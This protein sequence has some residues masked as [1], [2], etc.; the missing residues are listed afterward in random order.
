M[1][2]SD[3]PL[4][5][6]PGRGGRAGGGEPQLGPAHDHDG[7]G[8]GAPVMEP[9][10]GTV[11]E[12]RGRRVA[13]LRFWALLAAVSG[14][15]VPL[16]WALEITPAS[17]LALTAIFGGGAFLLALRGYLQYCRVNLMALYEKGIAPPVKPHATVSRA[18]DF[19][20][21]YTDFARVE[22]EQNDLER[23][24]LAEEMFFRFTFHYEDGAR[25]VL[26]P[27]ILGRE[28]S[29]EQ[30][31]AF[32]DA[33]RESL[34]NS[35]PDRVELRTVLPDGRRPIASVSSARLGLRVGAQVREFAWDR[36]GKLR[37]RPARSGSA[38]NFETFDIMVDSEW[39]RLEASQIPR[40]NRRDAMAFLEEVMRVSR[41]RRVEV[42]QE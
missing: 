17:R 5:R 24:E 28:P 39:I 10:P 7:T 23:K 41:A 18:M 31:K 14:A 33:V 2:R 13:L 37:I 27:S 32:F 34:G 20:V 42:L 19:K 36:I 26:E 29:K 1:I 15:F 22:V 16:V 4:A 30:V 40:L 6:G 21:P 12:I 3:L 25:L 35:V 8:L 11:A 38:S 9:S